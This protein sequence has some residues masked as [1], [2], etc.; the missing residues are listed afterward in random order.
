MFDQIMNDALHVYNFTK[1]N[2]GEFYFTE[3]KHLPSQR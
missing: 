2:K 1:I 3:N